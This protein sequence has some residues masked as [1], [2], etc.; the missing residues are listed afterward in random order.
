MYK[1]LFDTFEI[2]VIDYV[3]DEQSKLLSL[4]LFFESR[5]LLDNFFEFYNNNHSG[6][7]YF[8][9]KINNE[10]F[11]GT[12]GAFVYDLNRKARV[13]ITTGPFKLSS[14]YYSESVFQ[15][16]LPFII[17]NYEDRLTC[18]TNIL[19]SNGLV[20]ESDKETLVP[21]LTTTDYHA[22]VADLDEYLVSTKSTMSDLREELLDN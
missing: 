11:N 19:A 10:Q 17:K 21:Y 2:S 7:G 18:L 9:L 4:D 15:Y 12:F 1:L 20:S 3:Y 22:E 16:N 13:Y 5:E 14:A 6:L 8:D